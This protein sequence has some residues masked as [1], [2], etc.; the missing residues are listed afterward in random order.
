M[1]C[2]NVHIEIVTLGHYLGFNVELILAILPSF[3]YNTG[4]ALFFELY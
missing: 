2:G 4:C 1:L 3:L